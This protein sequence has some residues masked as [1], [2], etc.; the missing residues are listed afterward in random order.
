MNLSIF[1]KSILKSKL[2]EAIENNELNLDK[3]EVYEL[4][5]A[6]DYYLT[7]M[8]IEDDCEDDYEDN[9]LG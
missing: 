6:Y 4:K 3:E 5:Q 8:H 2:K 1:K 7:M 9:R